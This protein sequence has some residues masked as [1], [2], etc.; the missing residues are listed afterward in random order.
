[1]IDSSSSNPDRAEAALGHGSLLFRGRGVGY[2]RPKTRPRFDVDI[3]LACTVVVVSHLLFLRLLTTEPAHR[4]A[5]PLLEDAL[6]VTF[7]PVGPKP[8]PSLSKP[9]APLSPARPPFDPPSTP[10]LT[11]EP[12]VQPVE[13]KAAAPLHPSV[14]VER[15][16]LDDRWDR[17]ASTTSDPGTSFRRDPLGGRP[18][19]PRVA[20]APE[21]FRMRKSITPEDLL[22]G[23]SQALG[24]WPPGY[25][26]DPCPEIARNIADL[27]TDTGAAGRKQLGLEL[28]RQQTHCR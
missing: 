21:R 18:A 3:P 19:A 14:T 7:L 16:P 22:K 9:R 5:D 11:V 13:S 24:L 6:Q 8:L 27:M 23:A 25:T 26:T 12:V 4:Y 28:Q 20:T 15:S 1:M 2:A 17:P 10:S